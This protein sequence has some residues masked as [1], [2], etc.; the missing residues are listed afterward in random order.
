MKEIIFKLNKNK[1]RSKQSTDIGNEVTEL[2]G[3]G[4]D[5]TDAVKRAVAIVY[6]E[7]SQKKAG[8]ETKRALK[9]GKLSEKF[10]KKSAK[11]IKK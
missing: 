7:E 8:K 4:I 11:K 2:E 5:K 6:S 1:S 9:R 10:N 3:K